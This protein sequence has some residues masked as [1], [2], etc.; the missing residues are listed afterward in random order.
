MSEPKN[1][2]ALE[3]GSGISW[4]EW[5]DFLEPHKQLDH[6]EMA[7]VVLA[8][9]ERFGVSKNPEWWAQSVTIAFEQYIGRR[10]PGQQS[11]GD[12]SVTVTKT[13][14][15][16]MD[17]VLSRIVAEMNGE[18]DFDGVAI[19]GEA[20]VSKTEK[21]RYWRCDLEDGSRV[22]F[23]IQTKS[24]GDKSSVAINHDGIA[25]VD[26]VGRWRAFW[27]SLSF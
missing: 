25:H 9:I 5:I 1:K 12:Y 13:V 26:D 14:N 2:K 15:G 3:T 7:K 19:Q 8:E 21:W 20:R 4:S 23:N 11:S 22:A 24:N 18:K 27:K 6:T 10:K 16:S 17:E